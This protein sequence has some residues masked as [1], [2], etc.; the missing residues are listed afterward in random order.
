MREIQFRAWDKS[1]SKYYYPSLW[2]R[3]MPSNWRDWY[4]LEQFTGLKDKN[5]VDI[6]EGDIINIY[7]YGEIRDG[8]IVE[9]VE[10]TGFK[11]QWLTKTNFNEY[12]HVRID[13]IKIIGNI[14]QPHNP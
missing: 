4:I 2:D 10:R 11:I 7:E 8:I 14:H 12:L 5:G 1:L 13:K 9:D 6:Y 3:S